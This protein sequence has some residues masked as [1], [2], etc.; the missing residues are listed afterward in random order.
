MPENII[1]QR[2]MKVEY[3]AYKSKLIWLKVSLFLLAVRAGI[4]VNLY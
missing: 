1:L 2:N 4:T 3:K